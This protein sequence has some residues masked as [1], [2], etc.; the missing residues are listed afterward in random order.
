MNAGLRCRLA[1][2]EWALPKPARTPDESA[3]LR[4]QACLTAWGVVQGA[5]ESLAEA[6][7]R[8]MGI[9]CRELRKGTSCLWPGIVPDMRQY[10]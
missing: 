9:S 5:N 10:R 8:G 1:Q 7:A 2:L 4:F 6:V 3:I